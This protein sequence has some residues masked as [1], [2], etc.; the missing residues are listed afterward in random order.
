MKLKTFPLNLNS[1]E[2]GYLYGLIPKEAWDHMPRSVWLKMHIRW[3][4]AYFEH[5]TLGEQAKKEVKRWEDELK[6][7]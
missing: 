7:L 6:T 3:T 5:E 4:R 1:Q 2:F